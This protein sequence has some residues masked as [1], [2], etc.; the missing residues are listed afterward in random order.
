MGGFWENFFSG[1]GLTNDERF[2]EYLNDTE[3]IDS[4][5]STGFRWDFL[6]YSMVPIVLGIYVVLRRKEKDQMY[7]LLLHTYII[8]NAFWIL[9]IRSSFSN[10]FAYLSWFLYPIV[11][12]YP[13]LKFNLW[14]K[15]YSK[16]GIIVLLHFMF[17]YIMWLKG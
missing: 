9:V 4:F 8:T 7:L 13:A 5:S 10:R 11:L 3:Y 1:L 6:L 2:S 15:Q 17:T 12:I 14:N 16:I